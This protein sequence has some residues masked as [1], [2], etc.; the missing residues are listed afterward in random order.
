M[1]Q[2]E[3]SKDAKKNTDKQLIGKLRKKYNDALKTIKELEG[4]TIQ[5]GKLKNTVKIHT[6][7]GHQPSGVNE[8]TV[9]WVASDWHVEERVVGAEINNLNRYNM[10]IAKTRSETFFRSGLRITNMLARDIE[11]KTICL[12][13][14]GDF[15][16]NYIHDELIEVNA[17]Q[18]VKAIIFAQNLIASGIQYVLDN[19]EYEL[20]IPCHSGN[21]ARIS[22]KTHFST[23]PGHSLEYFMYKNLEQHFAGN[24]RVKFLVSEGYHSYVK[25]HGTVLRFHHGHAM[26]YL[27][28][29]GGITIPVNKAIAQ[30]NRAIP[31]DI[32]VFGC[33][34]RIKTP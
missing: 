11:I 5:V 19:S 23:E 2:T 34:G 7:P 28:G 21:H 4:H 13:L 26:R 1:K 8:G 32:D 18:P 29:V 25:I 24:S 10:T 27:G 14:L 3:L 31:A 16:T 20:V 30:W 9:V 6:V 17:T 15:I 22:K 12:A 33:C